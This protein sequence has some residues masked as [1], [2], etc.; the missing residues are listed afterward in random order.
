MTKL[1]QWLSTACQAV[2][3]PIDLAFVASLESGHEVHCVA[4]IHGLGAPNGM[5]I[6]SNFDA[7]RSHL[8]D[9][10]RAHYGFSVLD[11][12]SA[13]EEFDLNGYKDMFRDWGWAE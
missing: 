12:P 11:E 10:E 13:K 8:R 4:R 9:L 3:L 2:G 1:Q 6:V 7:V 5:L